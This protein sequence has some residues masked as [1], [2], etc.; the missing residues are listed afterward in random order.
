MLQL[1]LV[2]LHLVPVHLHRV[3]HAALLYPAALQL[4]LP[5]AS[6]LRGSPFASAGPARTKQQGAP[7]QFPRN[8]CVRIRSAVAGC[9]AKCRQVPELP[10]TSRAGR[11]GAA[12]SATQSA[13]GGPAACESRRPRPPHSHSRTSEGNHASAGKCPPC[14]PRMSSAGWGSFTWFATRIVPAIPLPRDPVDA[15]R[16]APCIAPGCVRGACHPPAPSL[17]PR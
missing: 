17:E 14:Q 1:R 16:L 11:G 15:Y 9:R 5:R 8:P 6:A 7:T 10:R 13:E 3:H 2:A 4:S 12:A